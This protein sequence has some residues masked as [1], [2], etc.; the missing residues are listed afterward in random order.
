MLTDAK[1]TKTKLLPEIRTTFLAVPTSIDPLKSDVFELAAG[2]DP[3]VLV[4]TAIVAVPDPSTTSNF[5][6][7][8][9]EAVHLPTH[10]RAPVPNEAGAATH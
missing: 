5:P 7:V 6:D 2:T 9:T 1:P 3:I 10:L 4:P 8:L